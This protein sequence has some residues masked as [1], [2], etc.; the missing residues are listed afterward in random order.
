MVVEP[1]GSSS[2]T[3]SAAVVLPGA[4]SR[5][6]FSAALV[7]FKPLAALQAEERAAAEKENASQPMTSLAA[8]IRRKFTYMSN[9]RR[10]CDEPRMIACMLQRRGEYDGAK[11]AR[12][13]QQGGTDIYLK[14][15]ANKARAAA[16]WLQDVWAA[17]DGPVPYALD[18]TPEPDIPPTLVADE[19]ALFQE[20]VRKTLEAGVQ[21][22][23]AKLSQ[24]IQARAKMVENRVREQARGMASEMKRKMDDQFVEGGVGEALDQF[25]DDLVTYPYAVIKGPVLARKPTLAWSETGEIAVT[26]EIRPTWLRVDPFSIYR[27]AFMARPD[28]GDI[29]ERHR[30]TRAALAELIGRPG[31]NDVAIRGALADY[32][33]GGLR[34]W[35]SVDQEKAQ[36]QGVDAAAIQ[37]AEAGLIDALECWGSVQGS[38]L[39]EWG[40]SGDE[41]PDP[42]AEYKIEAWL[43]GTWVIRAI[44][45]TD[46]FWR[47]PY[48]VTSYSKVPGTWMGESPLDLTRD[49]QDVCNAVARALVNNMGI[50]SGP[51]AW[52]NVDRLPP[53]EKITQMFPW[54]IW[55]VRSDPTGGT[56]P[57]VGFFQPNSLAGELLTVY[58]K[59][60]VMADELS[61]IPRYM[62]GDG[63]MQGAGRTASGMSMLISNAGKTIKSVLTNIDKDV[64]EPLVE[65]L[66]LYNMRHSNDPALKGDVKIRPRGATA[67]VVKEQATMRRNEFLQLVLASPVVQQIVG[68]EG[69]AA[70]LREQAQTLDLNA[71]K[72]VPPREVVE[73]R[74][75]G[76]QAI[77]YAMPQPPA[78]QGQEPG[79]PRVGGGE[80]LMNGEP[81]TDNFSPTPAP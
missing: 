26:E 65:R 35:L 36:A 14:L 37:S 61:G 34:E 71:D 77:Q 40:M 5:G 44:I 31:Y 22:Q 79:Q 80:Q 49:C 32:G 18:A 48:Y 23:P 47:N 53:G 43:V 60:S 58:E 50:A 54:K 16:S 2:P 59:F 20:E 1:F 28:E 70:L 74:A 12:I 62:T 63:P 66:W 3:E 75:M 81:V 27:E 7:G 6:T 24:L 17:V 9:S 39:L 42:L 29:I 30:L 76:V 55:Q 45:N 52:V 69:V 73:A 13:Q 51:Q 68:T 19:Y 57:P 41:V 4:V 25:R 10:Q 64:V 11:L 8:H 78:P 67:L 38:T 56:A 15:S 33:S 21:L 72:I 46:P